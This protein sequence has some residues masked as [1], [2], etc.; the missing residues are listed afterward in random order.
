MLLV[1]KEEDMEFLL[2]VRESVSAFGGGGWQSKEDQQS[3]R[4]KMRG[5][6]S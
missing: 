5:N 1:L 6:K 2:P 4:G 3:R